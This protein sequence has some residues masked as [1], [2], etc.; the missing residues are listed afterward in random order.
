MNLTKIKKLKSAASK[1]Q[2]CLD[3]YSMVFF[4]HHYYTNFALMIIFIS[5]SIVK[6]EQIV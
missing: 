1:S 4:L 5:G 6:I 2:G 3:L